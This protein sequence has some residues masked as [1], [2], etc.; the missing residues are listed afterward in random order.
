MQ[1]VYQ[2]LLQ[3]SWIDKLLDNVRTLFTSLYGEKLKNGNTTKVDC[4]FDDY[5][6]RQVQELEKSSGGPSG[7]PSENVADG[8]LGLAPPSS[9]ERKDDP[10]P[11]PGLRKGRVKCVQSFTGNG[12]IWKFNSTRKSSERQHDFHR[13]IPCAYPR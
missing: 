9:S 3:L 1:A 4:P 5:F 10:P 8:R 7:R 13:R 11:I 12:L 6:D 2:S